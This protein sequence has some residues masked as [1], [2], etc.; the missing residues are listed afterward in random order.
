MTRRLDHRASY[1]SRRTFLSG[2][3]HFGAGV[4][5][6]ALVGCTDA[7]GDDP[8]AVAG[9]PATTE[10]PRTVTPDPTPT[11]TL[12]PTATAKPEPTPTATAPADAQPHADGHAGTDRN[13]GAQTHA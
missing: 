9:T 8:P 10:P 5:G 3:V 1:V 2:A 6:V 4:L 7:D 12:E 13:G 11:G